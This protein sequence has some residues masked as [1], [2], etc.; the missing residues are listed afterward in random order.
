MARAP[1]Y[2]DFMGGNPYRAASRLGERVSTHRALTLGWLWG[3]LATLVFLGLLWS[4][5]RSNDA[6]AYAICVVTAAVT[7]A[8]TW[9]TSVR[10]SVDLFEHGVVVRRRGETRTHHFHE[11][12]K[13]DFLILRSTKDVAALV[14][15]ERGL[16]TVLPCE[17]AGFDA[18]VREIR[19]RAEVTE[20]A[21]HIATL[22]D[23]EG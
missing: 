12:A 17:L 6:G 8:Y 4:A 21:R 3:S 14:L 22:N 18:L 11:L 19:A 5:R 15:H 7:T 16:R 1:W 10:I 9:K 23:R 20:S 2:A 13:L